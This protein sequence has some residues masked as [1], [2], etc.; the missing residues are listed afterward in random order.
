M[1]QG[2]VP[3][4]LASSCPTLEARSQTRQRP[5]IRRL[6]AL[7]HSFNCIRGPL[8]TPSNDGQYLR[9]VGIVGDGANLQNVPVDLYSILA[10]CGYIHI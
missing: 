1:E 2:V 9:R 5:D 8:V 6:N 3:E 10:L 7:L 4:A